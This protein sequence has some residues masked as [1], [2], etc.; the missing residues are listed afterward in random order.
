MTRKEGRWGPYYACSGFP[1]CKQTIKI[2]V[3]KAPPKLTD[4]VCDKCGKQMVIRSG[5]RGEFL[6]CSGYPKCK[7][8]KNFTRGEDGSI[9]IVEESLSQEKC[10]KCGAPMTIK[11]GR[12]GPF[13]ACSAYPN[14]KNIKK[15][16]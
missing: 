4:I 15:M 10:D 8:A 6:A 11:R 16:K 14:C 3:P 1:D 2:K 13:L 7:N 5:R 12:Y 9:K